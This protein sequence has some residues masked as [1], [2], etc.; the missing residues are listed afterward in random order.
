[1]PRY[2]VG[3]LSHG[4]LARLLG[5]LPV[6]SG[7]DLLVGPAIGEDAAAVAVRDQALVVAT[8]PVT[9]AADRAGWYAVHVNA[10]DVATMGARPRWFQACVLMPAESRVTV[11]SVFDDVARACEELGVGVLGGH[12]E[13]TT[14]IE[15]PI[16]IGTMLG[17]VDRGKVLRT[18]GARIG[19][20]IVLTKSAAIEATSI[21]ARECGDRLSGRVG[22]RAVSRAARFLFDPGISVVK[23][24]MIA[25]A[26]GATA[27][28][29]PTEGGVLTGLWEMAEAAGKRFVVDAG[30]IPVAEATRVLC[31]AVGIDPLRAIASGCLLVTIGK[32]K[33]AGLA[34][35]LRRAG[36]SCA[37]VG[38]VARGTSGLYDI[39][40]GKV[41]ISATDEIAKLFA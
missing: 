33:V 11:R 35:R 27:M 41:R 22:K 19:D 12:T 8:D 3:K 1:M 36:I 21:V 4:Q 2:P 26:A 28:H 20:A 30:A 32:G 14:G 38:E 24:A 13:V 29:D 16:V 15:H 31:G 34:R 17:L 6:G 37:A 39:A 5:R 18:G 40:G 10:N 25:A 23:E 9:F 7:R